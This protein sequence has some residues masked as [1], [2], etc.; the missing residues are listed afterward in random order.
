[1]SAVNP[2]SSPHASA[3]AAPPHHLPPPQSNHRH[4]EYAPSAD[5][6]SFGVLLSEIVT[7]QKPYS[8]TFMT[9]VQIALAVSGDKL[10]PNLPAYLPASLVK[11]VN[12][13]CEFEAAKRPGFSEVVKDLE[14]IVAELKKRVSHCLAWRACMR[15]ACGVH[16][17]CMWRAC[18]VPRS[19]RAAFA[20]STLARDATK[21]PA[22]SVNTAPSPNPDRPSPP[23]PRTPIPQEAR[24]PK[25][26]PSFLRCFSLSGNNASDKV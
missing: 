13:C 25:R 26:G 11:L 21:Q 23:Q 12:A 9:P 8:H 16:V 14:E 1:M 18:G 22:P 3:A 4:D 6:W 19:S 2:W 17:A 7:R 5:V 10:R 20:L 24:A 15:R